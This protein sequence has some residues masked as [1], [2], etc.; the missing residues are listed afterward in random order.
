[1][2]FAIGFIAH[3]HHRRPVGRHPRHRAVRLPADR[4]VLHRRP[5]PLRAVRRRASSACSPAST[6]GGRRSPGKLLERAARQAALLADAHRLQP[7]VRPDAHPRPPGHAP[8]HLHVRRRARLGLLEPVS[9]DRRVHHRRCRSWCS[10]STSS[11][12]VRKPATP[13]GP[14]P[15]D[16]R[17]LE[18][19][20]PL[21]A[22]RVQLRRDPRGPLGR[23]LLAPEVRRGRGRRRP[24]VAGGAGSPGG[25]EPRR[26][27]GEHDGHDAEAAGTGT[28]S[29]CRRPPTS[30]W[31][32]RSAS[33][34]S[35][36]GLL[37][38]RSWSWYR[39]RADPSRSRP[40]RRLGVG[41]GPVGEE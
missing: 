9:T 13:A 41:R 6:T 33:R 32:P 17:T 39:R 7:D 1:M 34:S 11:G 4:H 40:V 15:W 22:A 19:I 16:G 35:A 30:R 14:D 31:S 20:D 25:A 3:V 2:L 27:H 12:R 18:W 23:R 8:P 29:T 5:L 26:P 38:S 36:Y 28:A 21:A 37:Y 24:G 10:S